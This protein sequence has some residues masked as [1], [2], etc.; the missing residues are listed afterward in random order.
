MF[1]LPFFVCVGELGKSP[2]PKWIMIHNSMFEGSN[3]DNDD[4]G[5]GKSHN[6]KD[7]ASVRATHPIPAACGI[8]Y[9]EVRIISKGRDG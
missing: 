6:H 7:A 1:S 9:F 5:V 2:S 8:Y 3:E 4:T